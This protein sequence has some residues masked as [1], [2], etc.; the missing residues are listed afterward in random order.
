[1]QRIIVVA[2]LSMDGVMQ[3]P[4]GRTEDS[5]RGFKSGGWARR[6]EGPQ[7]SSAPSSCR[8]QETKHQRG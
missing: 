2:Q 1:M 5:T 8:S 4:G 6:L 3:A 7:G